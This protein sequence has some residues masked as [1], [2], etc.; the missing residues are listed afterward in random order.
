MPTMLRMSH[1]RVALVVIKFIVMCC[2]EKVVLSVLQEDKKSE[3]EGNQFPFDGEDV[4][5]L[6]FVLRGEQSRAVF[7]SD[8]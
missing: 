1:S 4:D 3:F 7:T 6:I 2:A 8:Q 5:S